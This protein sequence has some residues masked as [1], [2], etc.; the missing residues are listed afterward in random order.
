MAASGDS[1]LVR[2]LKRLA[3]AV[4]Y[5]RLWFVYPQIALFG[6]CVWYTFARL[7]FDMSRNNLVGS[8]KKYHEIYL[9]FKQDFNVRD[10]YVVVVESEDLEKNRQFVER[11][12]TKLEQETNLFTEVLYK[13]DLKMLGSKALLFMEESDLREM[14]KALQEYRPFLQ[15]F[16]QATNL[17]SIFG[18][19]NREFRSA[20]GKTNEN[21]DSLI[22]SIP[23]LQRVV[24]LAT[25]SIKRTGT[26]P[27]P[28]V[29]ALF[30]GG[31]EAQE[32]L[33]VT[34]GNGRIYLVNTRTVR[35]DQSEEGVVRLRQL[36]KETYDEVPGVNVGLTGE[37]ILEY[38]E[39]HQS[40]KDSTVAT[41]LSLVLCAII[42]IVSYGE[43][44]RPLKATAALIIGLGYT[45]GFTT[46]AVGH[47]NILTVTFLPILIGLAIDFGVHLITRYEEELRRG[48][49]EHLAIQRAMVNTGMGIFTGCLTTAGAFYAMM[50]TDFKGIKEMGVIT[51]TGMVLSLLPMMTM[52]P[53]LI[54]RG[55]QNKIDQEEHATPNVRARLERLWLDRPMTVVGI[56]VVGTL[57]ALFPMSRVYFDYNLLHMQSAGLPA[58]IFQDKLINSASKSVLFAAVVA[59]SKEEALRLE[60][61][62]TNLPTVASVDSMAKF[63]VGDQT[64]KMRL[65]GEV[66]QEVATIR[67]PPP[68]LDP[69]NVPELS[70]TLWSLNGYLGLALAEVQKENLPELEHNLSALRKSIDDL[71]F[72]ML[73]SDRRQAGVKLAK[74]QQALFEDLRD[75]FRTI[76]NQD[77]SSPLTEEGLPSNLRSRFIGKNGLLLLQV[78]PKKDVWERREQEEF[79]RDV[80]TVAANA[81]GTPVQLYEYTTLL[82]NSYIQAAYYSLGAIIIMVWVHFRKLSAVFLA[83]VPV[84]VG[85]IWTAGLMGLFNLPFNPAN[86]MTLPLVVGIGVTNG[87]HILNRFAEEQNPSLLARS[88]GKA[89]VVSALNTI[90]GFGSL[91]PA[92]HLGIRSLGIVMSLGVLMC[93]IAAVTFLPAILTMMIRL[94]WTKKK[95]SGDNAQSTLGR[96]EPRL[97]LNLVEE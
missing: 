39:M 38:D 93:M 80:R 7:E 30:G 16:A 4:Y 76:R 3:G 61:A 55:R 97:N 48:S 11:L 2:I 1:I 59:Q 21:T 12:G 31:N 56:V 95:P 36:V 10:D 22:K 64:Q 94:G 71:R 72:A 46:L 40:Q 32:K 25:D 33:Y 65:V 49:T 42:F 78:Y 41:I 84:A 62:L 68:D 26:P 57:V 15:T 13:G 86:I 44:G 35:E 19:I 8:D 70:R 75:T 90:A 85:S 24:D 51:G 66:K 58:V 96:E 83:L 52:L 17:N 89:V 91:I 82:K 6:I 79:V 27:S 69:V 43:T 5:W 9:K 34:F 88:T 73:N 47:L 54:L 63:L 87:I 28:G 29:T 60:R 37:P 77:N 50:L 74:Y 20:A 45:M 92:K 81:T 18:L 14:Q 67:F 23:A 53:A